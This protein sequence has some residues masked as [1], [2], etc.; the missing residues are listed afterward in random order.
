MP[1]KNM[2][3]IFFSSN[4]IDKN[5]VILKPIWVLE[6]TLGDE[7][8]FTDNYDIIYEQAGMPS[9]M[10]IP[11][12]IHG[13]PVDGE[14][15]KNFFIENGF[16]E[17]EFKYS[18]VCARFYL[19][20][21]KRYVFLLEKVEEIDTPIC[22][23]V[24][25]KDKKVIPV[26]LKTSVIHQLGSEYFASLKKAR[27]INEVIGEYEEYEGSEEETPIYDVQKLYEALTRRVIGQDEAAKVLAA[28]VCRN[29]R[30]SDCE[31]MKSNILLY[32]PTGC[33]KTELVRSLA[34]ELN[35]PL[36]IEDMTPYTASGFVGDSVKKILRRLYVASGKNMDLA[37][38]GIIVLDE[39]DKLASTGTSSES[40]NKSDVQ[41]ELLKIVEGGTFDLN[42]SNRT[43]Q[44]LMMDTSKITFIFCGAFAKLEQE[45]SKSSIPIG[46]T[47]DPLEE[48]T[49]DDEN[50]ELAKYGIIPEL[51][52]RIQVKT[53]VRKLTKEDLENL[54][55]KSS[56]SDLKVY[57]EALEKVDKI[58]LLYVNKEGFISSIA[59]KASEKDVGARGIKSIIDNTMAP[60]FS[61]ISSGKYQGGS[62]IVSSETVEN[63][64]VYVLKKGR[65]KSELSI[66]AGKGTN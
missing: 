48:Q 43:E 29:L 14:R 19:D 3:S 64:N 17:E 37:E 32:G 6:G 20:F 4:M 49:K 25:L 45:S 11:E 18:E 15:L 57:E 66:R 41:E 21:C 59:E 54:I 33:G 53:P 26:S 2:Y 39:F 34:K 30:Y 47:S 23:A 36:V 7:G 65:S 50:E 42:D 9:D 46:F 51:V 55:G 56:I 16:P 12:N 38:H 52:G 22:Y 44:Q 35:V 28:T 13:F 24:R 61:E 5:N 63:P 31:K 8:H 58:K 62:L 10:K 1:R 27:M 40:V 60:A